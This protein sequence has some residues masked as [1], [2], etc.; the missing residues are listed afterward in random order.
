MIEFQPATGAGTAQTVV[1]VDNHDSFTFNLAQSLAQSGARCAVYRNDELSAA[2]LLT[3]RCSGV[4]LSPGPSRP[5]QAGITLDLIRN[6][7]SD[8]PILGVCL[9]HQALAVAFGGN[10]VKAASPVH[11]KVVAIEHT[12]TGLFQ[13]LASPLPQA[14]YNSLTVEPKSLPQCFEV[15]ARAQGEIMALR[16]RDRPLYGVQF[17]PESVLSDSGSQLLRNWLKSLP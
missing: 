16:H 2:E 13:G 4:L 5:E 1:I 6:A 11:G 15:V 17:H 12:G 8:L 10:V 3:I 14:R 7:A 9:G